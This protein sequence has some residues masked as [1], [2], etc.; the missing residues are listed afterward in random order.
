MR[1]IRKKHGLAQEDLAHATDLDRSYVGGIERGEHNLS[2]LNL[3]KIAK[4]LDIK[5]SE[6]LC[7][8][9]L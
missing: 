9:G 4:E 6:L 3:Q 2:V 8:A 7:Q 5:L 1:A